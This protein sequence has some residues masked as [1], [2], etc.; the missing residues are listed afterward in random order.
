[1]FDE[2]FLGE[3]RKIIR[4]E[5]EASKGPPEIKNLEFVD[6]KGAVELSTLSKSTLEKLIRQGELKAYYPSPRKRTF[7][8][9]EVE[10]LVMTSKGVQ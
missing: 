5:I 4:E 3:I 6:M 1:M 8:R 10:A 2:M 7:R 9:D